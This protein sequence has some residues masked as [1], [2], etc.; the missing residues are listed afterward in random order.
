LNNSR[1]RPNPIEISDRL[2]QLDLKCHK[3]V[4]QT[5]EEIEFKRAEREMTFKPKILNK[6]TPNRVPIAQRL[7][8]EHRAKQ[9]LMKHA[10]LSQALLL[11]Q[12][13]T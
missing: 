9:N 13:S 2:Y 5:A 12:K 4:G 3:E 6:A 11:P 8:V 7:D 10:A 1:E